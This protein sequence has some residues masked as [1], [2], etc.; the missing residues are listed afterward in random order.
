MEVFAVC[1]AK[2]WSDT[3]S[4]CRPHHLLDTETYTGK[5]S[6]FS[7]YE[8]C[9]ENLRFLKNPVSF[10]DIRTLVGGTDV[11]VSSTN[12]WKDFHNLCRVFVGRMD[13]REYETIVLRYCIW[14]KSLL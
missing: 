9:I 6:K 3:N 11:E 10:A 4:S 13:A 8:I 14:A 12:M 2:N 1:N 7:K 5:Y